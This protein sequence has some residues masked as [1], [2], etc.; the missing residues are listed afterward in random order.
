[1]DETIELTADLVFSQDAFPLGLSHEGCTLFTGVLHG[2]GHSIK[3]H[4]TASSGQKTEGGLFC[5]LKDATIVDLLI[6][7]SCSFTGPNV[8]ALTN[9]TSGSLTLTRVTNMADITGRLNVGGLVGWIT[10]GSEDSFISLNQ[11]GN[12]GYVKSSCRSGGLIGCVTTNENMPITISECTNNGTVD[13]VSD[14][15][16]LIGSFYNNNNV[17]VSFVNSTNTGGVSNKNKDIGGFV[18]VFDHNPNIT[19]SVFGSINTL[20]QFQG[21]QTLVAFLVT[22]LIIHTYRS[23]FQTS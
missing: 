15:G 7:S 21:F 14:S 1:M 18:G 5:G 10:K 3:C 17:T 9:N 19:V 6:D 16:G 20:A 13:G 2:N 11:C 8:G 23:H 4:E 22:F 12:K